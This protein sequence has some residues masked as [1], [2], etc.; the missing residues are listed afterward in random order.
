MVTRLS[1]NSFLNEVEL[2]TVSLYLL[3]LGGTLQVGIPLTLVGGLEVSMI[4]SLLNLV[5]S[6]DVSTII[7]FS[8]PLRYGTFDVMF[9]ARKIH[10]RV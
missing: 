1:P 2:L 9:L 10:V 7:T 5:I 6:F 3:E 4:I 8:L